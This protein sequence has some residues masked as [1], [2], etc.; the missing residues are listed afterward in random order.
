MH[1]G[2]SCYRGMILASV[3]LRCKLDSLPQHAVHGRAMRGQNLATLA[4][5]MTC[6]VKGPLPVDVPWTF[7]IRV[8]VRG[9]ELPLAIHHEQCVLEGDVRAGS[10]PKRKSIT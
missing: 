2:K 10:N 5:N 9:F 6:P 7:F 8:S 3:Y 1:D 4:T